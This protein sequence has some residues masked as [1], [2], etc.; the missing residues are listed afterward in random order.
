MKNKFTITAILM[1]QSLLFFAQNPGRVIIKNANA[2]NPPFIASLNGVRVSNTYSSQVTFNFLEEQNYRVKILQS[3]SAK[4]LN[5]NLTSDPEYVSIYVLNK[6]PYGNFAL[7]MQ[8]KS[9]MGDEPVVSAP[10]PTVPTTPT[11]ATSTPTTPTSPSNPRLPKAVKYELP[12]STTETTTATPTTTAI[13]INP[14][15]QTDFEE[16]LESIKKT[17]FDKDKLEKTKLVF[18]GEYL[19]TNQVVEVIKVFSFDN[20]KLDYA[21][22]AYKNTIDKKNYYKVQDQLSFSSSKNDLGAWLKKQP[23]E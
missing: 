13:V 15:S 7:I 6:D 10:T 14:I 23:K 5:F 12:P 19:Y 1:I 20:F 9:L 17:S 8:S 4:I 11:V 16:R 18:D 3:G 22:W 2:N 21:K